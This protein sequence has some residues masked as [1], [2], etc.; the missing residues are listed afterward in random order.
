MNVIT[1][2]PCCEQRL[3][4]TYGPRV[5]PKT[6][7]ISKTIEAVICYAAEDPSLTS[8]LASECEK[9]SKKF[10]L[11]EK[12]V[13]SIKVQAYAKTGQWKA[14]RTLGDSRAKSPIGF[15][16]FALAVIRGKQPVN[17]SMRY[18]ERITQPEERYYLFC[19]AKLWK[20]ALDEAMQL[21]DPARI[22]NVR[23]LCN[24]AELQQLCE[25][26]VL[27]MD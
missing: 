22:M 11:S 3:R 8:R 7:S 12:R 10:R 17:D 16:P 23:S 27:Q 1:L 21:R 20:K 14:L 24:D 26:L 2:C 6:S 5:T 19:E 25:R 9:L 4:S 13:W 18:I 15:K